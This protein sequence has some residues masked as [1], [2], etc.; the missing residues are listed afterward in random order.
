MCRS[1]LAMSLAVLVVAATITAALADE[2][3]LTLMEHGQLRRAAALSE[4]RIKA[5]PNDAEA[6]RVLATIRATQKRYDEAT[7]FAERAVAAAPN[8]PGAHYAWGQ[9]AG[10]QA[11][12]ASM[13]KKPGLAGRFKK[14]A[15]KALAIDPNFE[16]G[17]EGMIAFH[18]Q[19]PGIMGGDKKKG[20]AL[21]DRLMQMNPTS[22]WLVKA[23]MAFDEK[24]SVLAESCLRKAVAAKGE[25]RAKISLASWLI[26]S[27]LKPDEGERLAREAVEAEPWRVGGWALIAARQAQQKRFAEMEETLTKAE[28]AIPG[29]LGPHYQVARAMISE[30]LDPVRAE[31]LLRRYLAVEPEIGQPTYAGAHWRLGQALE[32]QGKKSEAISEYQ[33]ASKLDPKLDGPKQDLKRLKG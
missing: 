17:I 9:V 20:A 25:P 27:R 23:D 10:M 22:A 19:A 12:S 30:K 28:A 13:L 33:T 1:F 6:L 4:S 8:D 26:Q 16:D 18:R 14:G 15:E 29:N 5:N 11:S 24:D 7:V 32:L 21:L 2:G 3:P 31:A